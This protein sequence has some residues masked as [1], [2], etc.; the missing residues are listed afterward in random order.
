MT[1]MPIYLP[2]NRKTSRSSTSRRSS[3]IG[4]VFVNGSPVSTFGTGFTASCSCPASRAAWS[5]VTSV[6]MN[7]FAGAVP[8]TSRIFMLCITLIVMTRAS[9]S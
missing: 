3:V 8:R 1:F 9:L 5:A 4:M 2:N 6:M 7:W